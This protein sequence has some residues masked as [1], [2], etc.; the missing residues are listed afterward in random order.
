V[1]GK[2]TEAER[3]RRLHLVTE[4]ALAHL[5]IDELLGAMLLRT[6]SV[7]EADTVAILLLDEA[8]N[9]LV[10]RAAVGL[11]EEV[12]RGVRIPLGRGFAGRVAAERRPI[13][14]PDVDHADVLNPLLREKGVKTLAG[15]PL[16][17][18]GRTIGVL[19][20]GSLVPRE[21]DSSEVQL[22]QLVADRVAI[23]IEHARLYEAERQGR[24][25]LE[26]LQ[27]V[28]D[29][30]LGHLSL[31]ELSSELLTR[32]RSIL[33]ADTAAILLLDETT[34]ELVAQAAVGLEE[35]VERGVRIPMGKGFAGRVAAERRPIFLPDL[36][37]AD[38]VNPI[39]REKGIKSMLGV[40]LLLEG[41]PI[42]VM[43]VGMLTPREFTSRDIELLQLVADRVAIAIDKSRTQEARLQVDQLKLNFVAIASHELRT[44]A[45]AVYGILATLRERT[46]LPPEVRAELESTLWA[47]AERMRLLI[48]QLLDLS[49]LDEGA[50]SVNPEPLALRPVLEEVTR[51]TLPES[52]RSDVDIQVDDG[53][54]I[55]AD[56]LALERAVANLLS[57]AARYARPPVVI[58]VE[59]YDGHLRI[60]I[61][62]A[63]DGIPPELVPRLF[64]RFER[65]DSGEGSGLGLAIAKAYARAQGGDLLYMAGARGGARFELVLPRR[66][67]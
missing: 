18:E 36:A 7:L 44:P 40:P 63:G 57:N 64:E 12:E 20:V 67:G 55:V 47:Q 19:H 51:A 5:E 60:A 29:T 56:R 28:T 43:H 25:L 21:F 53:L 32:V 62:D 31:S 33:A 42:G 4:A 58:S 59:Q 61:D 52:W 39:L 27:Q 15:V 50:G 48:E 10:A 30:A 35:E 65:G 37:K 17:V 23:A 1:G 6:R 14:L 45:T 13:V 9:E 38:V 3:L 46:S 24:V 16:L 34:D 66:S 41:D 2:I 54:E 26:N 11:E 22:L 49:R 8:T